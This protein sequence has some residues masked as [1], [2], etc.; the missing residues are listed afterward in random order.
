M[1][2]RRFDRLSHAILRISESPDLDSVLQEVVDS[3]RALTGARCG[4]VTIVDD[5][6]EPQGFVT[7]GFTPDRHQQLLRLPRARYEHFRNIPTPIRFRDLSAHIASLGH[8]RDLLSLKAYLGT[9]IRYRGAHFGN[10]YLGEK[11][12]GREF[13]RA[14]KELLT[15]FASQA[16]LAF[17]EAL[18]GARWNA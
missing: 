15:L 16:V 8:P 12:R 11:E 2:S 5:A 13:T 6:G 18:R 17:A 7:S 4:A 9:P 14:D 3:T 10:F 1:R